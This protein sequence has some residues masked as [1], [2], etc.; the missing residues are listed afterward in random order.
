MAALAL[1]EGLQK[2]YRAQVRHVRGGRNPFVH[3]PHAA[4]EYA[5]TSASTTLRSLSLRP[6]TVPRLAA[7]AAALDPVDEASDR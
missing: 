5:V 6:S 1:D 3:S 2:R 7:K 4:A